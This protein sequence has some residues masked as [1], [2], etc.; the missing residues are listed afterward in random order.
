MKPTIKPD[1][2]ITVHRD[3]S[4]SHWDVY[5]QMYRRAPA[6]KMR[7]EVLASLNNDERAKIGKAAEKLFIKHRERRRHLPPGDPELDY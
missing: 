4:G 2:A 3:G 7:D 5:A 1:R 6:D